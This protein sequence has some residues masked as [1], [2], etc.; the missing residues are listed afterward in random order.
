MVVALVALPSMGG[1]G[2]PDLSASAPPVRVELMEV[3]EP[4]KPFMALEVLC[5]LVLCV[6]VIFFF[7]ACVGCCWALWD[8]ASACPPVATPVTTP[9][10]PPSCGSPFCPLP[11]CAGA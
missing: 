2:T 5:L 6:C 7:G 8:T 3:E 4:M 11:P 1:R 9:P 10:P